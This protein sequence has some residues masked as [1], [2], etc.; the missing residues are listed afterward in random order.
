MNDI[1]V[2]D[3]FTN[4]FGQYI[5]SGFGLLSGEV[6]WLAA[7][8]I[9]IDITLAGLFWALSG[10]GPED[11]LAKLL[12]K[13]LY[14]GAFAF[15]LNNFNQLSGIIFHSFA[16]L[17]LT[18]SGSGLAVGDLLRPGRLA[19]VGI[20]AGRPILTQIGDLTGFPDIFKNLDTVVVL[21]IA[22]LVVILS[23]FA[24]A[25]QMFVTLIEFKL[26]TLAGF[27]L[28]PFA[29]W[30]KTAFLAER[31]LGNVVSSGV[32]VLVLAV[33]VGIGTG[34]FGQFTAP[35]GADLTIDNALA[36]MLASLA[37][38][39]LGLFGPSI[40]SGLVSGAPQLGAGATA[41]TALAVGGLALA[42]GTAAVGT[43]RLAGALGGSA[44]RAAGPAAASGYT[45]FREGA[46]ASGATGVGAVASGFANVARTAGQSATDGF[47]S[48]AV[49]AREAIRE[50]F[51][52]KRA[53]PATP[54][55]GAPQSQPDWARRMQQRQILSHGVSAAAQVARSADHGGAG[56]NP[57]LN[58]DE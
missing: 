58:Q 44:L 19:G 33:I 27:V 8:L 39:G 22:W 54:D 45:A 15:I 40:A 57:D 18:A 49:R 25:V 20:D 32:K 41:G 26:T 38:F 47:E 56:A 3:Q 2:I 42:G 11:V 28:L 24:L 35:T 23:F 34:I 5:D 36:I 1:G 12:K 16:G 4:V 21:F 10:A 31:V 55:A 52:F 13:T 7:T 37:L 51:G 48:A 53:D 9:A 29:L 6:R 50:R 30:N 43:A 17:G 14:V 46:A